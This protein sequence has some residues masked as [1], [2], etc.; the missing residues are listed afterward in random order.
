MC[1]YIKQ[2]N[3]DWE[4][5]GGLARIKMYW[6]IR[7]LKCALAKNLGYSLVYGVEYILLNTE[8]GGK[9]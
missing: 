2:V 8:S 7:T 3:N 9:N 4:L 1:R 6:H 5:E